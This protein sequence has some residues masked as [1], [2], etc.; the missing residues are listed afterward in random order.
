VILAVLVRRDR[1]Q[2]GMVGVAAG[3]QVVG[4]VTFL[5]I[6]YP[7]NLRFPVNSSGAVPAD[8]TALR[9][10]WEL[11]HAI[12]FVLFA[13]SFALLLVPLVRRVDVRT[14]ASAAQVD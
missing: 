9:D 2:R 10:R 6:I 12:G 14:T 8:W 5:T 4:L 11:G 1:S 7:V 13:V 3:L